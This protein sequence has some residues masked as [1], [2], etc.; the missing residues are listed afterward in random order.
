MTGSPTTLEPAA[1]RSLLRRLGHDL[2]F[3]AGGWAISATV[4]SFFGAMF[5][6][7]IML[8][9]FALVGVLLL[10]VTL[11]LAGYAADLTRTRLN[12]WAGTNELPLLMTRRHLGTF[13]DYLRVCLDLRLWLDLLF[14]MMVA[15]TVRSISLFVLGTW[16]LASTA[17]TM[18]WLPAL[19]AGVNP[20]GT[21]SYLIAGAIGIAGPDASGFVGWVVVDCVVFLL[22]GLGM[23]AALP[24]GI[25]WAARSEAWLTRMTLSGATFA[26]M[27]L[28]GWAASAALHV[29]LAGWFII[30][31]IT[32][33]NYPGGSG[34][35]VPAA[36]MCL[37]LVIV[38]WRPAVGSA[39]SVGT[40]A[41]LAIA[42]FV[43]GLGFDFSGPSSTWPLSISFA[44]LFSFVLMFI[45]AQR[46]TALGVVTYG[47]LVAISGF[48]LA[49]RVAFVGLVSVL[50]WPAVFLLITALMWLCALA[51]GMGLRALAD[52]ARTAA[53]DRAAREAAERERLQALY[54]SEQSRQRST[55]LDERARIAR[56]MHDVVAHSMSLISVQAQTAPYR[57]ASSE[58]DDVT[59]AEFAQIAATSRSAL[60][61][62]RG[63]LTVLRG[64]EPPAAASHPSPGAH[65]QGA[66]AAVGAPPSAQGT[67]TAPR[68]PEMA[69][70]PA[71]AD[72]PALVHRTRAAGA[73]VTLHMPDGE[74][75]NV[76]ATAALTL[77]RA[78][79]EGLSNALRHAPG[80]PVTVSLEAL[81]DELRLHVVNPPPKEAPRAAPSSGYGL[82]GIRERASVLGGMMD[83]RKEPDGGFSLAV[84]LPR[85]TK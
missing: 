62:M 66:G 40:Y 55:E 13:T 85:D 31:V 67:Q 73:E 4:G 83:A 20:D 80:A 61:E 7:S 25:R 26:H 41:L 59:R 32:A 74:L 48:S 17:F 82:R 57:L 36:F 27:R 23:F 65:P 42:L 53:G 11:L 21:L 14:E 28:Q 49:I 46:R 9:P 50:A 15:A 68:R 84:R 72:I 44:L 33:Q 75:D 71:L 6:M 35:W 45:G 47:A 5:L 81:P 79:Q 18:A 10:P 56:E 58:L 38:T 29:A 60:G 77:Y 19:A 69:P 1:Q 30:S 64:T 70:Q 2:L 78:V 54:E 51:G 37:G 24:L 22:L 3:L 8:L 12:Y 76:P 16:G 43:S 52:S 63:L 34:L 39:I